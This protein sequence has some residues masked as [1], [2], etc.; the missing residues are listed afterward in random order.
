MSYTVGRCRKCGFLLSAYSLADDQTFHSYYQSLS[1][2]DIAGKISE[3]DQ[4][5]ID[6]AIKICRVKFLTM[7]RLSILA[8]VMVPYFPVLKWQAG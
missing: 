6:V 3:L 4:L 8:A 1:K 7:P 2:Y 5:R